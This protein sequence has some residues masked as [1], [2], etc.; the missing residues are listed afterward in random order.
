MLA[1]VSG[2]SE[3]MILNY[4]VTEHSW[5]EPKLRICWQ[6]KEGR[7]KKWQ[8]G[9]KQRRRESNERGRDRQASLKSKGG[10]EEEPQRSKP[11]L[12]LRV[13]VSFLSPRGNP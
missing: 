7:K 10:A 4:H 5:G 12:R 2:D 8:G 1:P 6:G 9:A 11:N 3:V 13:L